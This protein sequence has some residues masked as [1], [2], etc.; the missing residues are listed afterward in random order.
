M[1]LENKYLRKA[2]TKAGYIVVVFDYNLENSVTK[3]K[4][5][6]PNASSIGINIELINKGLKLIFDYVHPEDRAKV[7]DTI[8][9]ALK[10]KIESYSHE[11]RMVDDM[12]NVYEVAND[13]VLTD[14]ME[15]SC[16]VECYIRDL[17]NKRKEKREKKEKKREQ[18]KRALNGEGNA[19]LDIRNRAIKDKLPDIIEMFARVHGLYSAVVNVEGKTVFE[20]TGPATNMGDFYDLF[21]TPAYKEYFKFILQRVQS[22]DEVIVFDREEGG[23]GKLSAVPIRVVGELRAIWMLGSYTPEETEVLK[24]VGDD[25]Y[26][27]ASVMSDYLGK[28]ARLEVESAKSKGAGRKL[29]EEL[30]RQGIINDALSKSNSNLIDSVDQVIEETLREVGLN[31]D[32]DRI[33]LYSYSKEKSDEFV[34][35]NYWDVAGCAPSEEYLNDIPR[36]R[37]NIVAEFERNPENYYADSSNINERAKIVL[38]R[39]DLTAVISYIIYRN[40][41]LYGILIFGVSKGERRWTSDELRFTRSISYIIQDMLENAEG[42]DNVRNVNKHLI[43][44]YNNFN[45][46]IFVRDTYSGEILFSNKVMNEMMGKDFTGGNCREILTDLHDRFDNISGMRKPFIT[47]NR[48]QSWR[49]YIQKFDAIMDITEVSMEWLNGEP[50]ALVILRKAKEDVNL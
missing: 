6:S 2:I 12:G 23:D 30:A 36:R 1:V 5:I 32:L 40:D 47:E 31:M 38:L 26:L 43:E 13:L 48:V 37:Y 29:C 8:S 16:T 28:S 46:G 22:S 44:T 34:L 7:L 15:N 19:A 42:D 49:S 33:A 20:P 18:I 50:A 41:K 4:Y 11:Y 9:E 45:V 27:I 24:E 3:V 35:R 14:F 39:Y 17:A 21:E 25:Q 10:A